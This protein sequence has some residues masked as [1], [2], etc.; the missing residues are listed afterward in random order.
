MKRE[1]VHLPK[2]AS[3]PRRRIAELTYS[4]THS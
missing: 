2:E 4:S 3:R 1:V